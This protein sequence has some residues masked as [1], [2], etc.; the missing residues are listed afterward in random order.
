MLA[1]TIHELWFPPISRQL[2]MV[3]S[4]RFSI[5]YLRDG[6]ALL[7]LGCGTRT[8][9]LWNNLDFSIYA[10]LA[11]RPRLAMLGRKAGLISDARYER[12]KG[13][14]ADVIVWDLRNGIPFSD[15]SFDG[16]YHSHFL[17]HLD[18]E[19]APAVVRECRRV[20]KPGG[21]L[22]VVVPDLECRILRYCASMDQ[23][24][25]GHS[26]VI[27]EH[28][29]AIGD[30]FE[31]VV[32][33]VPATL[34]EQKPLVQAIE[35]FLLGTAAARGEVHKWMY[36]RFT[37]PAVLTRC[38]FIG[39][40]STGPVQGSRIEDWAEFHLDNNPDGTPHIQDSLYVEATRPTDG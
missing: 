34:R 19:V 38:G 24:N 16:V 5:K 6:R 15:R 28:E 18:R 2:E 35:R 12:L 20:L 17:E 25:V 32:R 36:D 30:I 40:A 31:Q 27:D 7:N 33:T 21:T 22:R 9:P 11:R 39:A 10:R 8:H 4:K 14:C 29:M 1:P 23:L 13:I 26:E 3:K 37:L